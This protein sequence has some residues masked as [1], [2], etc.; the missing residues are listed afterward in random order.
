MQL[1]LV[2]TCIHS[3]LELDLEH[4]IAGY[5]LLFIL[6]I[7]LLTFTLF[8]LLCDLFSNYI[9]CTQATQAHKNIT[10]SLSVYVC[11]PVFTKVVQEEG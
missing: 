2:D 3:K 9:L 7:K 10:Q 6:S 8:V 11:G 1:M 5:N 4:Y